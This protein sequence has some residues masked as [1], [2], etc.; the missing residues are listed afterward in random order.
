MFV[1][2]RVDDE[3]RGCVGSMEARFPD[4]V[5]ET[6]N[7]AV[8]AAFDDPR[9]SPLVSAE[10]DAATIE[11]SVLGPAEP[12]ASLEGL[13]PSRYG[14]VVTVAGGRRGVLLP[15]IEG[16]DTAEQQVALA[17]RKG[18]IADDEDASLARFSVVKV[19]EPAV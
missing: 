12:V 2:I 9:F 13:D 14:V 5:Q 7:R 10:L 6:A 11:V 19:G 4:V 8:L 16:I 3:L 15:E 18:E 1:T 17:R